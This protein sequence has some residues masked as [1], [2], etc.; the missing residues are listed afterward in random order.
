MYNL[1][2]EHGDHFKFNVQRKSCDI[3]FFIFF[4]PSPTLLVPSRNLMPRNPKK[5]TSSTQ[6]TFPCPAQGCRTQVQSSWGFS[7]HVN[8]AHHGMILQYPGNEGELVQFPSSDIVQ[9]SSPQPASPCQNAFSQD[10]LVSYPSVVTVIT[11]LR[12][13]GV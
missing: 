10:E 1:S 7:Q 8:S 13:G 12:S 3:L 6:Q 5:S 4:N 9:A 2:M 11:A